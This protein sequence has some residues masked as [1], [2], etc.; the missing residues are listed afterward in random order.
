L[1]VEADFEQ[2]P[3]VVEAIS[4]FTCGVTEN[5]TYKDVTKG[6]TR[7]FKVIKIIYN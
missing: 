7:Y 5:P 2:I 1:S 3:G 6:E 4:G